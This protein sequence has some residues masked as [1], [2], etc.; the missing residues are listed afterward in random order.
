MIL[1]ALSEA[2]RAGARLQTACQVIGLSAR[3]IQRWKRQPDVDDR[4]CGPRH[5]PGNALSA[6]EET[7]V[8]ALLTSAEYGH[9]SP[10]QLVPRLAD[11]GRYL[12]SEST[13]YRLRRRLGWGARQ[14][15]VLRM[16]VARAATVH[17][18]VR[19]NQVWSW[20]ITYLPTV[21]RGRFLRLYLVMDVWSRRIVGWALHDDESAD[22]AGMLI[23]RICAE[24]GV[25]PTGL[26]LHSDNGKP[27]RGSTM[28]AT[29]QWLGIV[30][31]FSRPH[32]CNDNPYSEALF[33]TLKHTPAYP[34]LPFASRDAARQWVARFVSWYNT[35]HRHSAIR[36]VTPDQRHA[37]ADVSILARRR[38][39]YERAR[40]RTPERWS[41]K[42]RNWAPI[43]AVVLNPEP[44]AEGFR[45]AS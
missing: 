26:V 42:I 28:I 12:A 45:A 39:L 1:A 22:R 41:S 4:R 6:R 2:Q 44:T 21:I 37:G 24:S 43:A 27:M 18:A 16:M 38:K 14:R 35:E 33:R 29:L 34:R 31:S 13:M 17:R 30:P 9:L 8:L 11:A 20:D 7:Q 5:R 25:D 3:T 15:P 10:K 32:V 36:Y 23:Q 40:Q 19:A